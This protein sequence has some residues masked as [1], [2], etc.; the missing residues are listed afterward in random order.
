[1]I[2]QSSLILVS[3]NCILQG[4]YCR[5]AHPEGG[6]ALPI[7][8]QKR[9]PIFKHDWG[10]YEWLPPLTETIFPSEGMKAGLLLSRSLVCKVLKLISSWHFSWT[11]G[12]LCRRR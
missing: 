4:S 9:T 2:A 8:R 7:Q 10:I 12:G 5:V 6:Q 3:L 1:M 11:L